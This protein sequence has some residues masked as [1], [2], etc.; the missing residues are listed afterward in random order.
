MSSVIK[1]TNLSR[2]T[3]TVD[4]SNVASLSPY[5]TIH[6]RSIYGVEVRPSLIEGGGLGLFATRDFRPRRVRS[7]LSSS[8]TVVRPVTVADYGGIVVDVSHVTPNVYGIHI[9][10]DRMIDATFHRGWGAMANDARRSV[11][12][13]NAR[14]VVSRRPGGKFVCTL[15]AF[16]TIL[17]GEE[18]LASYGPGYWK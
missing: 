5:C 18:I 13:N 16:S 14:L 15:K 9:G 6:A 2:C 8:A 7:R 4:C 3:G 1:N 10:K 12:K 17:N 11:F